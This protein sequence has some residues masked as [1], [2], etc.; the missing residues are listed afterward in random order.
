MN[1]RN[2]SSFVTVSLMLIGVSPLMGMAPSLLGKKAATRLARDLVDQAHVDPAC[3]QTIIDA[4]LEAAHTM[5]E[6]TRLRRGAKGVRRTR[7][8]RTVQ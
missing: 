4:A 7:S 8:R 3:K 1:I 6:S 2:I 5:V